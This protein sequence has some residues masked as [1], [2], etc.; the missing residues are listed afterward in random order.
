MRAD[1]EYWIPCIIL[2]PSFRQLVRDF[3]RE[4]CRSFHLINIE[5][6]VALLLLLFSLSFSS[7]S[8]SLFCA[9]FSR[10]FRENLCLLWRAQRCGACYFAFC[11]KNVVYTGIC[12]FV[13]EKFNCDTFF[14]SRERFMYR[15]QYHLPLCVQS[16]LEYFEEKFWR[17][18]CV[19]KNNSR[20][21][22]RLKCC[23]FLNCYINTLSIPRTVTRVIDKPKHAWQHYK[24]SVACV[25]IAQWRVAIHFSSTYV[26]VCR[27]Q[28]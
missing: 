22:L 10:I 14:T 19:L 5:R 27:L 16:E 24:A 9:D 17:E 1:E 15:R 4:H 21:N 8:S 25:R 7:S 20:N 28:S 12:R 23:A 2:L 18:N 3:M 13:G 26:S 6:L 11:K